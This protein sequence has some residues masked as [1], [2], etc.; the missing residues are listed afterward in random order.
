MQLKQIAAWHRAI[1][2]NLAQLDQS[3]SVRPHQ[4]AQ[5]LSLSV[6]WLVLCEQR[7]ILSPGT[8]RDWQRQS[9]RSACLLTLLHQT[10]DRLG[11][12]FPLPL[13]TDLEISDTWLSGAGVQALLNSD[14]SSTSLGQVY[15]HSLTWQL[16]SPAPV[17]DAIA[18]PVVAASKTAQ[19][20][21]QKLAGAYY[22]PPSVVDH[23]VQN[24]IGAMLNSPSTAPP[25]CGIP[26]LHILDPACGSGAFLLGA[27]RYLLDWQLQRC[28]ANN[29]RQSLVQDDQGNWQLTLADR[30]QLLNQLYGVD[31]DPQ[32]IAVT[33]L[34]L[35]L[36]LL[37]SCPIAPPLPALALNLRCGNAL[38]DTDCYNFAWQ[39]AFPDVFANGGFDVV[40]GN[41]PYLDSEGM[42]LH[43]PQW[44]Q[45]CCQQYRSAV[46]NWDL[47]CVFIEKAIDLCR[48]G[49]F[50]SLIVPNKLASAE[51]AGAVRRLLR[52]AA[53][54]IT[55]RDYS[56]VPVFAASVYPLAFVAQK[57]LPPT[58]RGGESQV[59]YEV[60]QDLHQVQQARSIGL[61][62]SPTAVWSLSTSRT[63]S[64]LLQRLQ[65]F[66]PLGGLASVCGAATVAEAYR[67]QVL[68]QDRP[69]LAPGDL[70]LVNSGTIDRYEL[71]WGQKP[72]RYLGQVYHH[73]TIAVANS[74]QL[75]VKRHQQAKQAKI[76]VAGLSQRLECGFDRNGSVLAGKSTSIVWLEPDSLAL[77]LDLRYLLALL[78]S[79]LLSLYVHHAFSGNRL[80]GGYYRIGPPQLRLLPIA[81]PDFSNTGDRQH[82]NQLIALVDQRLDRSSKSGN[83]DALH[84][85]KLLLLE[86]EIDRLVYALYRFTPTE[87]NALNLTL[88]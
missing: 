4:I 43:L 36:M 69:G 41:P 14:G 1:A 26:S 86:E 70:R 27:Y 17:G 79:Q 52:Q 62:V 37:E 48:P 42:A 54:L 45:I 6:L 82:Y 58:V 39:P 23:M 9:A 81:V 5:R 75:P 87:S 2:A 85:T 38:I 16:P 12:I 3:F 11:I 72:L 73:P 68:I 19:T 20:T 76:I 13:P 46:G 18:Q 40:L 77:G 56:A 10:S 59:H 55:I 74:S 51:Y 34:A 60:M 83:P 21:A 84:K 53:D 32:A 15:E 30:S 65:A 7:G 67:L 57:C 8:M 24:T 88:P 25:S 61:S 29:C 33:K 80:H 66:P 22:T 35:W 49:G 31:I 44:R 64:D 50:V 78:N 71:L 63:Q 47:F 28:L